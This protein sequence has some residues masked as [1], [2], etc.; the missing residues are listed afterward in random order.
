MLGFKLTLKSIW[1][2]IWIISQK[3]G[4][5]LCFE[6]K[7]CLKPTP[8]ELSLFSQFSDASSSAGRCFLPGLPESCLKAQ[9]EY[10]PCW[11]KWFKGQPQEQKSCQKIGD[12][13]IEKNHSCFFQLNW[14]QIWSLCSHEIPKHAPGA[15]N[16]SH[17]PALRTAQVATT[18]Q[19]L[20]WNDWILA[21][22]REG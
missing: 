19:G 18:W 8:S 9:T 3:N 4:D 11:L 10:P 16:A 15:Y 12:T 5:V 1:V 7:K 13:K 17:A 6:I 21:I 22:S 2:T 20:P 14:V